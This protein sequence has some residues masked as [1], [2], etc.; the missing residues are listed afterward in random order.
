[1]KMKHKQVFSS[2]QAA[3]SFDTHNKSFKQ[4]KRGEGTRSLFWFDET[5][6]NRAEKELQHTKL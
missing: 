2:I 5:I 4:K 1:M 6:Q 3:S